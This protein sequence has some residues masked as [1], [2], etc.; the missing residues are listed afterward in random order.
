MCLLTG[1]GGMSNHLSRHFS[2]ICNVLETVP[3]LC[4]GQIERACI[5]EIPAKLNGGACIRRDLTDFSQCW[6]W[7][8]FLWVCVDHAL[9]SILAGK[10]AKGTTIDKP[11]APILTPPPVQ[12]WTGSCVAKGPT[13]VLPPPGQNDRLKSTPSPFSGFFFNSPKVLVLKK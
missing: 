10:F 3:F 4:G 1:H 2:P 5:I 8:Y 13:G 9:S 12:E 7:E 6:C 11:A